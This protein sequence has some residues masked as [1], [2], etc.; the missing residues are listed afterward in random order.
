MIIGY[1]THFASRAEIDRLLYDMNKE[2]GMGTIRNQSI[3]RTLQ[4]CGGSHWNK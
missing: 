3:Y 4:V 1:A 2:C